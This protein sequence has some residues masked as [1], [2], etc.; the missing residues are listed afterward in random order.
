M[1]CL[2]NPASARGRSKRSKATSSER[3]VCKM[4]PN[5]LFYAHY[6]SSGRPSAPP[7]RSMKHDSFQH[8]KAVWTPQEAAYTRSLLVEC[9][10]N[11]VQVYP[12]RDFPVREKAMV[13]GNVAFART[14]WAIHH[15]IPQKCLLTTGVQACL[16]SRRAPT[17]CTIDLGNGPA[18]RR[19]FEC[20]AVFQAR[21]KP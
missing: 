21:G 11:C 4:D 14:T 1:N 3:C 6:S 18:F 9:A 5:S 16:L 8:V 12:S 15:D 7:T 20:R 13:S 19:V 10:K 17:Y 2:G